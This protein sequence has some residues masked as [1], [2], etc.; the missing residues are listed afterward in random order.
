MVMIYMGG[1]VS[2]AH[3]NP[4]VTLA[5]FMRGA[6]PS[7]DI[8]P[9]MGSQVLGGIVAAFVGGNLISAPVA[10][11]PNPDYSILAVLLVEILYTFA[12]AMVVLN[13]ATVNKSGVSNNGYYGLAIG[14]TIV[15]A[16]IAGGSISGGA[17]N[18]AVGIGLSLIGGTIGSVWIYLV[19][20]FVGGALAAIVFKTQN[21]DQ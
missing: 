16:A 20:P 3:Y 17:Y 12:L 11:A 10:I 8:A 2:G 7:S 6:M 9:Y 15:A 21:P 4:A 19:G 5:V 14:F 1:H 13:V 18:P